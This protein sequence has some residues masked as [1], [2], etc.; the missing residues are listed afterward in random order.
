M[1]IRP[2]A[3]GDTAVFSGSH[4][5]GRLVERCASFSCRREDREEELD[6]GEEGRVSWRILSCDLV[7]G[8]IWGGGGCGSVCLSRR[9]LFLDLLLNSR[10]K[11]L[12]V[13]LAG[14]EVG[15]LVA[16]SGPE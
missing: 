7:P 4:V 6:P 9:G 14:E 2:T 10:G 11:K 1:L 13:F 3:A 15:V 5:E 12:P 8:G 16:E